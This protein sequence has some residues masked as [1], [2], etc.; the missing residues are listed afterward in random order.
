MMKKEKARQAKIR[1]AEQDLRAKKIA[2]QVANEPKKPWQK[3]GYV[4]YSNR[5]EGTKDTLDADPNVTEEQKEQFLQSLNHVP[6]KR[7]PNA[8]IDK[9]QR[10]PETAYRMDWKGNIVLL[11][12]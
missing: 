11:E 5:I 9:V 1:Q 3:S 7:G 4:S 2:K 12:V 8:S 10:A 6:V